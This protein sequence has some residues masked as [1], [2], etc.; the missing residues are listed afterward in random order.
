MGLW[1]CRVSV[2][3]R[4]PAL[5][6][7]NRRPMADVPDPPELLMFGSGRQR[8]DLVG[9]E[10]LP[11]EQFER[12]PRR[13]TPRARPPTPRDPEALMWFPVPE[14]RAED[15]VDNDAI[16]WKSTF[17]ATGHTRSFKTTKTGKRVSLNGEELAVFLY[18]GEWY[19]VQADCPHASGPLELG[20]VEDFDDHE[21]CVVCPFHFWRFSL[22]S[23][24]GLRP[25]GNTEELVRRPV[26]VRGGVI[27]I[28]FESVCRDSLEGADF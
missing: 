20:D 1:F 14:L 28:G 4:A 11:P 2:R 15:V 8:T 6:G 17:T 27:E 16:A 5:R 3:R 21:P 19:A 12:E 9:M 7:R 13:P 26:R 25:A 18:R 24:A 10:R 23:G 22:R